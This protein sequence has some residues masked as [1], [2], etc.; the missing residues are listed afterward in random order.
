MA[1]FG[2]IGKRYTLS[3]TLK[4]EYSFTSRFGY[5]YQQNFIYTLEDAE[6]N[7]FAWK[8]TNTMSMDV[9]HDDGSYTP[10]FV[11]KGDTATITATVKDHREYK[12]VQQTILTRCKVISISHIPT[13]E[14]INA[15]RRE[16]Q[17]ISLTG[18]DFVWKMPYRQYKKHYADCETVAG[19]YDAEYREIEVI[20]REGRLAPSGVRGEHYSGYQF[21]ID[22]TWHTT[23]RAVSEENAERRCR[24]EHPEAKSIICDKIYNYQDCHRVW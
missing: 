4:G 3:L 7:I 15:K 10:D 19:S 5:P 8:T 21:L 6:G 20:I 18:K 23:Y 24:E 2:E 14:E 11:C 9:E 16:E 12:G 17:I 22:G 1:H 13:Q